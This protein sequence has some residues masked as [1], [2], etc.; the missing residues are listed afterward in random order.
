[1]KIFNKYIQKKYKSFFI[2]L[3]KNYNRNESTTLKAYTIR[4]DKDY[5]K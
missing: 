5:F 3:Y 2:I 4:K 1:M